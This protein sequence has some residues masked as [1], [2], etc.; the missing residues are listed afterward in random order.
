[1]Y[2]IRPPTLDILLVALTNAEPEQQ[3]RFKQDVD[4]GHY[5]EVPLLR[6]V[7]AY[8]LPPIAT[9]H[10]REKYHLSGRQAQVALL[11]YYRR[12]DAEIA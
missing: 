5:Q 3:H 1:M 4:A 9:E 11:L 10:L 7:A 6:N 8:S 2:E 12:T